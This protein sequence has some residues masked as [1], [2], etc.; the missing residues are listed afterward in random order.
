MSTVQQPGLRPTGRHTGA[1]TFLR[2]AGAIL[3]PLGLALLAVGFYRFVSLDTATWGGG[4]PEG[5][6]FFLAGMLLA[7][8]GWL[9]LGAGFMGAAA[10]FGAGE[11]IPTMRDSWDYLADQHHTD[12]A[13]GA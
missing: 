13:A 5:V 12:S 2:V 8:A 9:C 1:R 4:L 10:R 3:L 6:P 7:P 11:I